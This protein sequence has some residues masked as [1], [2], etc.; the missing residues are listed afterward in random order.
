M[1]AEVA[2]LERAFEHVDRRLRQEHLA[3][4]PRSHHPCGAVD[5]HPHVLVVGDARLAAVDAHP[6]TDT[7]FV[8]AILRLD[9]GRDGVG[10]SLEDDEE[11]VAAG[12]EHD[13]IGDRRSAE[14]ITLLCS[15]RRPA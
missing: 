14:R 1:L 15:A 6:H 9:R 5:V 8:Q 11:R 3:A 7:D 2:K 13:A 10:R 4:V 12:V